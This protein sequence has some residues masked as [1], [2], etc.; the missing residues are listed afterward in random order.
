MKLQGSE[1]YFFLKLGDAEVLRTAIQSTKTV[2]FA[3]G[4]DMLGV[5]NVKGG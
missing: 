4:A 5:K 3:T 1:I 2:R